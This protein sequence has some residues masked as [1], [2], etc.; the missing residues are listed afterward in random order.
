MFTDSNYII[1]QNV[2]FCKYKRG[3][4]FTI[5]K[6]RDNLVILYTLG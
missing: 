4:T 1:T 3:D 5:R 6:T 2:R